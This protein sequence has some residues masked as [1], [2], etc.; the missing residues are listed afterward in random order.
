MNNLLSSL[1]IYEY[2]KN[3]LILKNLE[4]DNIFDLVIYE[5]FD[6]QELDLKNVNIK[7]LD[8]IKYEFWISWTIA[9]TCKNHKNVLVILDELNYFYLIPLLKTLKTNN[10]TIINLGTGI[11]WYLNKSNPDMEDISTLAN[12]NINLYE[13]YDMKSFF[14]IVKKEGNKYIRI[15]NKEMPT[16]IFQWQNIKMKNWIVSLIDFELTWDKWTLLCW[17]Y[18]LAETIQAVNL[19]QESNYDVF[20]IYN[21]DFNITESLKE[22]ILKTENLIIILDQKPLTNIEKIIKSILWERWLFDTQIKFIYPEI[23]KI[24]TSLKDYLFT[25]AQFDWEWISQKL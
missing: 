19:W 25:Q 8:D 3:W 24:K 12:F 5:Q 2:V 22:S 21:Y 6:N 7:T 11:S 18:M 9:N 10:L 20:A 23:D 13:P 17:W 14:E 1:N 16:D 15:P 4:Q